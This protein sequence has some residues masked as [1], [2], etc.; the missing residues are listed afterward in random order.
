MITIF[1]QHGVTDFETWKSVF[2]A[3]PEEHYVKFNIVGTGIYRMAGDSG[4]IITHTFNTLEDAQKHRA[5]MESDEF[6]AMLEKMGGKA[7]VTYWIAEEV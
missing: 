6:S 2:D 3:V 5:M 1:G 7:P 4:V